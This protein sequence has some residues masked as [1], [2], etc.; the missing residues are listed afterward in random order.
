MYKQ[1]L[2]R[3]HEEENKLESKPIEEEK[4]VTFKGFAEGRSK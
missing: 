2:Y 1:T 3:N 4:K